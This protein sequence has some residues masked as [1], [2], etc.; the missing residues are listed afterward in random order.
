MTKNADD[1]PNSIRKYR[2]LAGLTLKQLAE[3]IGEA[4]YQTIEKLEHGFLRLDYKRVAAIASVLGA[5]V[6][7]VALPPRLTADKSP[8][9]SSAQPLPSPAPSKPIW[10]TDEDGELYIER[11]V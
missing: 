3:R 6:D 7:D 5:T 1:L 10:A 2:E 4:N 9:P 8:L 11:W